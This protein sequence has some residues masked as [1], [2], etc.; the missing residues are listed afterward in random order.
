MRIVVCIKPTP[1]GSELAIS[2]ETGTLERE[3]GDLIINPF[4]LYA[5]EEAIKIKEKQKEV[6][7]TGIAMAPPKGDSA[8]REA[9]ALGCDRTI[10]L[11]DRE[12]AG[13]DTLA[14]S[15][16][17]AKAIDKLGF[18]LVICGMKS[19]DGD[20]AQVGPGIAE[21]LDISHVS[22]VSSILELGEKMVVKQM[23]EDCYREV[24][25]GL[26]C[27]IT[28]T[29]EIN[30]PRLPS[31]KNKLKAKKAE[32][33]TWGL[34]NL[35]LNP[36]ECGLKGSPTRVVK[37]AHPSYRKE[38]EFVDEKGFIEELEEWRIL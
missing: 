15:R 25:V 16:T 14:T 12:F 28:V 7:I 2:P 10:L 32:I 1:E 23:L 5:V 22:W 21:F 3:K 24:E 34:E 27:L 6:E 18:D 20:T 30:D 11:T 13:A 37:T 4:D 9:L 17:L 33:E 8:L 26:P 38:V 19:T 31:F 36:Q 29:K 35:G